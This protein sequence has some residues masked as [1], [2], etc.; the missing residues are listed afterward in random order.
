MKKRLAKLSQQWNSRR[1]FNF[2]T[3]ILM[4]GLFLMLL[5]FAVAVAPQLL[6]PALAALL[7]FTGIALYLL[8]K[9]LAQ[10]RKRWEHFIRT[11]EAQILIHRVA[12]HPEELFPLNEDKKVVF[13]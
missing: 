6:V 11:F 8:G 12:G 10:L 7:V 3:A 9:K 1:R 5:G 4:P 13:H 2:D